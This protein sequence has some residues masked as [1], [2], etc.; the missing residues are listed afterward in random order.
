MIKILISNLKYIEIAVN[1]HKQIQDLVSKLAPL[2]D[3]LGKLISTEKKL[4]LL[5]N[6]PLV[7]DYL[8]ECTE[9]H[10]LFENSSQEEEYVI[11]A[12]IVI[13]QAPI[14]FNKKHIKST[15]IDPIKNLLLKLI[16]I[17]KFYQ[18]IGGIVG[19]HLTVL[20]LILSQNESNSSLEADIVYHPPEG[21]YVNQE[22]DEV[23]Q[24]IRRGI[25][26]LD[27]ISEIYPI[28]GAG[29][30]LNLIDEATGKPHPVAMLP[31]MGRTLLEG[32]I[33]DLQALEYLY[34]KLFDIQLQ[35][36][37]AMM[38]S[39]EKDND[40]KIHTIVESHR[41][42]GRSP[43]TYSF[44]T[45]PLVPVLTI[46]GNWSLCAPFRLTLKPGGHGIIWKLAQEKGVFQKLLSQN[47]VHALIRQINNP[48]ASTDGALIALS[49]MGCHHK[50]SMG[51]LS[52]ERLT[53]SAEGINV[54]IESKK[55][56]S[57]SYCITNI[58]YTDFIQKGI[59]DIPVSRQS[60]YSRFPANTNILFI[61][62]P[63]VKQA[64]KR[65]SIPGKL[66]NMKTK[67]PF[68]DENG[69]LSE[70]KG[71]RLESTMQNIADYLE[72]YF[73]N[74]VNPKE[75]KDKLQTFILFSDREKTIST[76][77]TSYKEG[78]SPLST[79]E[80][81][82]FDYLSNNRQLFKE[83]CHFTVPVQASLEEFIKE[84]PNCII[85][86]HPALG[87]LY[88]IIA[89]K[90]RG[91]NLATN[92][93]LQLEIAELD[94]SNLDLDGSLIVESS[95]PIGRMDSENILHYGNENR[96]FLKNVKITN[97]GIER[98][99]AKHYWKNQISAR[100]ALK[101][102]L[103][104]GAEFHAQDIHFEGD[105]QFEVPPY[106][107]LVV[108]S[109]RGGQWIQELEKISGPTWSWHYAFDDNNRIILK[110]ITHK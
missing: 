13:G 75:L 20:S 107:R 108:S 79:P 5:N 69:N 93:E 18:Q 59:T 8:K 16:E 43:E 57:Y 80:Q 49:G 4:A 41:W 10:F 12:I 86:F 9:I 24:Y 3:A 1:N 19:Y 71:G 76:T 33:R 63:A 106:H 55:D 34:Y 84:G 94:I 90:I 50:K 37:I 73:E 25:E 61:H 72:D 62:I 70:I 97:K 31:F 104:E 96:C 54:L 102:I 15:A 101:I 53:H 82:Y 81:A 28:G 30:R 103:H 6:D 38:T 14:L 52:C 45:Q 99:K 40:A 17:E 51:F 92:S 47:R 46:D 89:Q 36:P 42:F 100:Q 74:P 110:K 88:S 109:D 95:S 27:Q 83:K 48:L 78:E 39:E 7:E 67:V 2:A 26:N 65:C 77:K 98:Q 66:I 22:T 105:L 68:I 56:N 91:G 29:D 64:L 23:H 44:F 35:T 21:L 60:I 58:E 85:I 32:L 87:P 11:K